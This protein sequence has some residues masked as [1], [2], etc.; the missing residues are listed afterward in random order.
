MS[1]ALC[2][3]YVI[4]HLYNSEILLLLF[5]LIWLLQVTLCNCYYNINYLKYINLIN[6][7]FIRGH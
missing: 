1:F 2:D 3:Q 5:I 4:G 7:F 6:S